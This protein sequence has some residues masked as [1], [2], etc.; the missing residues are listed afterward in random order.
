MGLRMDWKDTVFDFLEELIKLP[1][2]DH[3]GEEAVIRKAA[4]ALNI[5]VV[6]IVEYASAS[7]EVEGRE[8]SKYVFYDCGKEKGEL[9]ITSTNPRV[10]SYRRL[11][12]LSCQASGGW[13]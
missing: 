1:P 11:D 12:A 4:D 10:I 13:G 2:K 7:D 3:P 6:D 9:A 8:S 5:A